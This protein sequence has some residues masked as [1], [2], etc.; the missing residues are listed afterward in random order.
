MGRCDECGTLERDGQ[1]CRQQWGELLALE[2]SDVRAGSV[3]FL[4]VA[5]YQLQ[6]PASFPLQPEAL[7]DLVAALRDAVIDGRD[8][9]SV[10]DAMQRR[11]D[12]SRPVAATAGDVVAQRRWTR[13]VADVSPPDPAGHVERVIRWAAAVV[14]DLAVDDVPGTPG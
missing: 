7:R 10:R 9:T 8:V 14:D 5:S 3:H 4:T 13:T 1:C 6:H 11:Y 12:G 2:F